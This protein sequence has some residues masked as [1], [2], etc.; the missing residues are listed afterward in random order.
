M[1]PNGNKQ[2]TFQYQLNITYYTIRYNKYISAIAISKNWN[3]T[4]IWKC[5]QFKQIIYPK[6]RWNKN[7]IFFESEM[8]QNF[9]G[10]KQQ[11]NSVNWIEREF[12][13]I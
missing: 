6:H 4:N 10:D 8:K 11:H 13:C 5:I 12:N 1:K 2:S 3:R 9:D 7:K